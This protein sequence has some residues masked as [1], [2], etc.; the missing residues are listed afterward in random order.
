[1][2]LHVQSRVADELK[3]LEARESQTL[4]ELEEKIAAEPA[5]PM[6]F[7]SG[8]GHDGLQ[9]EKRLQELGRE[10]IQKEITALRQRLE[11]RK[12][13]RD[14]D[15]GVKRAKD[16]VVSCLRTHDRRPLDCWK[17]VETFKK[18]VARLEEAFV[19]RALR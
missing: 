11:S 10:N 14:L 6:E 18:E 4:K 1:M 16:E 19:D 17:E 12:K 3:R 2:E 8:H 5:E 7:G 15:R 13:L 9:A